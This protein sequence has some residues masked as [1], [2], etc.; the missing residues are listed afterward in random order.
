[1][2]NNFHSLDK[3]EIF[4]IFETS[5]QGLN[6]KEVIKYQKKYGKNALPK[7]KTDP[8]IKIFF[9]EMMSPLV[10]ILMV[11]MILSFLTGEI[12]DGFFILFMLVGASNAVNLTDGLD[13]LAGSLSL[14]AF[15]TL[16]I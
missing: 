16:G 5:N 15:L 4:N 10:Y 6:D 11:T 13:G 9:K 3:K 7:K 2:K 8:F 12:V 1:M 14:I